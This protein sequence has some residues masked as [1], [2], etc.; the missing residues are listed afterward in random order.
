M[1]ELSPLQ[2]GILVDENGFSVED[3]VDMYAI[4]L[5]TAEEKLE[6]YESHP[7]EM[8]QALNARQDAIERLERRAK[9]NY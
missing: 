8:E 5:E 9:E 1:S 6:Y 2:V 3:I 4:S 7:E